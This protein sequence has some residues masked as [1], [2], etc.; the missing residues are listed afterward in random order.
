MLLEVLKVEIVHI[1]VRACSAPD[2]RVN[3]WNRSWFHTCALSLNTKPCP[4]QDRVEALIEEHEAAVGGTAEGAAA[5]LRLAAEG[6]K[7]RALPAGVL[8]QLLKSALALEVST[9]LQPTAQLIDV[10]G[11]W[12][13]CSALIASILVNQIP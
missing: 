9:I 13:T 4:G 3:T 6:R 8:S 1:L 7:P 5:A 2:S 12:L 10:N 11:M